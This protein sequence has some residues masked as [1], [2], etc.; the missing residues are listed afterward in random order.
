M[1]CID[2]KMSACPFAF[3]DESEMVQNYGCLPTPHEIATMRLEH[4]KTW[5]CHSDPSKPCVG[6]IRHLK[7]QG[8]PY[9]VIDQTL[10]T[11]S[12]DWG[13]FCTPL[14]ERGVAR[15]QGA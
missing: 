4:G 1:S 2:H 14:N 7:E 6:A 15:V 13:R 9:K 12:D 5:A 8:L 3:S 10:V 11:E